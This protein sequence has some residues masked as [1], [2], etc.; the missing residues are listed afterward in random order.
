[1][2]QLKINKNYLHLKNWW[3]TIDLTNYEKSFFNREIISFNQQLVR[4]KEKKIR[5]GVYGK[6]G[7]GKS[8][9]LNSLLKKNIFKTNIINGTTREIQVEPWPLQD[10]TLSSVEL[11]DSPGF[12]CCNIKSP[13]TV[14]S[15]INHS[16][17][18]LFIVSGDVNRNELKKISSLIKDGKKIIIIL[19]KIDLFNKSDLKEIKENIKS[20]LPKDLNIPIIINNGI[21]IKNYLTKI[22]NQYGEIFLTLNSLQL[23]DKL[24]LQIKEQRLKRRQKL[25]QSTIGKFST[26]KASAVALNPFILFDVAG[27]FA[28]DT[29]LISELSKIYGLKLKGKSARK[30]F[31]NISI[32]NLYLGVTQVGFNSSFNLIKKV[33][34]L[35]AP[36]TNGLSLLPY[37]PI[38]IIQAAI[39]VYSTRT[40]GKLA[41][42]EIFIRSKAS[43]IEPAIMIQN[44]TFNDPDIFN[45]INIYFSNRNLNNKFVSILP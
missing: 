44:M 35:S 24:F 19:N 28:L 8:S 23:A 16:D 7:V 25:A 20:K 2:K 40:L 21:N 3:E 34:L 9:V 38:A 1:M 14:Y 39:A 32:N 30:I 43:F 42:K 26:I 27:S 18:I 41:A 11:I 45:H 37:G 36:F 22:I 10:Q 17:L 13:D 33:I 4:L 31:K 15:Y 5:I 6:S 12:D 29:A